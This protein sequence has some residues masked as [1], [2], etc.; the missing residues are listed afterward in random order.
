VEG[1]DL[2]NA[3][4]KNALQA[5]KPEQD[6]SKPLLN[7]DSRKTTDFEAS[8][9]QYSKLDWR[10][11]PCHSVI[12][13]DCTCSK[14]QNCSSKGKHPR[15]DE[16]TLEHGLKDA[17]VDPE[18]ITYWNRLWPDAN[19]GIVTGGESGFFVVDVDTR[20]NGIDNWNDIVDQNGGYPDTVESIT[21]SGVRHILFRYPSGHKIKSD[22]NVL[23][24]GVDIKGDGGYFIAS[25]SINAN[26]R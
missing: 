6:I 2:M 14:K 9:L 8:A 23:A 25:P 13:Q 5:T 12:N 11:L 16:Q 18:L 7:N 21:G 26:G 22:S 3:P 15:F 20:N 24:P 10:L 1:V 4:I 19:I 17:T